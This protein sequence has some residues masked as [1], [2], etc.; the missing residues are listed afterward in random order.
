MMSCLVFRRVLFHSSTL[1]STATIGLDAGENVIC[2]YTNTKDA[3]ITI[4]KNARSEE[5]RVGEE[6][7]SGRA[8]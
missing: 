7:R 2:T 6:C 3:T 4:I 8:P 5:R 1:G